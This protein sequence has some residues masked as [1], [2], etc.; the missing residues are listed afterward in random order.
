MAAI[1]TH[2]QNCVNQI[3]AKLLN[4]PELE[5]F[6]VFLS[7]IANY[8]YPFF[9]NCALTEY[10][11]TFAFNQ[12]KRIIR[13]KAIAAKESIDWNKETESKVWTLIR[14]GIFSDSEILKE[15]KSQKEI[16]PFIPKNQTENNSKKRQI[17]CN[18]FLNDNDSGAA[19]W[20]IF[21]DFVE[22]YRDIKKEKSQYDQYFVD[23]AND[24]DF[25]PIVE[26]FFKGQ[27]TSEILELIDSINSGKR[28]VETTWSDF[29]VRKSGMSI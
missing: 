8:C 24:N 6:K 18:L 3:L 11:V 10:W 16:T 21:E 4:T 23:F 9:N 7:P 26:G 5:P 2:Q 15:I 25:V 1:L 20:S 28:K 29:K 22:K 12:L 13:I 27:K 17:F 19:V 14:R